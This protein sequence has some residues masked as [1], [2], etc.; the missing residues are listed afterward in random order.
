MEEKKVTKI[1]LSTAVLCFIIFVLIIGMVFMYFYYNNVININDTSFKTPNTTN[2]EVEKETEISDAVN[3]ANV[4]ASKNEVLD[5]NSVEVKKLSEYI[6]AFDENRSRV[7][8]YQNKKITKDNLDNTYLLAHAFKKLDLKESDKT[9]LKEQNGTSIDGWYSFDAG[10]LQEKVKEMYGDTIKNQDFEIG[11]GASCTFSNGKYSFSK[12]GGSSEDMTNINVLEKAYKENDCIYIEDKY[13]SWYTNSE[14]K[15][16][17]LYTTSNIKGD[18]IATLDSNFDVE[19]KSIS[20]IK[21]KYY[22]KMT[23]YKHTFK[24]NADGSYYWYSTEPIQ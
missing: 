11:Y 22:G 1:R 12:G 24:K 15:K 10:K 9:A 20:E 17:I 23:K 2:K 7:N 3:N 8:A 6:P 21:N 16:S 19:D 5:I 13:T 18:A 14:E 4:Q